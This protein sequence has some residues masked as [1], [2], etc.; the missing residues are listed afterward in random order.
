MRMLFALCALA[1][2]GDELKTPE[3]S[4]DLQ[5]AY[6]KENA[7]FHAI[8]ADL[9]KALKTE[10]VDRAMLDEQSKKVNAAGDAMRAACGEKYQLDQEKF[11]QG[12]IVCVAKPEP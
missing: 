5:A 8:D 9:Q 7:A 6:W 11:K 12:S 1:L 10:A 2:L 3:V 4:K